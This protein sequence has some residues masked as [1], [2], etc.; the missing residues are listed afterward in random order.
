V[1]GCV[2]VG[3]DGSAESATAVRWAAEEARYRS[4]PL[5]VLRAWTL[6]SAPRPA[7]WEPGFVPG[8][9]EFASA[10]AD[11]LAAD[12][13]D[14]L[15]E[16]P[17]LEV[18]PLPAHRSPEDALVTASREA[19]LVVVGSHGRHLASALLGSTSEHVVRHAHGPIAVIPV[20]GR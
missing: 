9:D 4:V 8:E 14:V 10:V 11:Q 5:V 15:G 6:T 17:G 16:D 13:V 12:L 1:S 3:D 2:V 7:H 20:R 19:Q 18:R